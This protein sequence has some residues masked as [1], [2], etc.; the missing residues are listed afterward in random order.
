[1]SS[2]FIV[3]NKTSLGNGF[4]WDIQYK[5]SCW[6]WC[7]YLEASQSIQQNTGS[8]QHPWLFKIIY[9]SMLAGTKQKSNY[10]TD[11]K[12]KW[13]IYGKKKKSQ[14]KLLEWFC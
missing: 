10:D 12:T 2:Y 8:V 1:M 3:D 7:V 5:L 9:N 4:H 11:F 6:K 14:L 13:V